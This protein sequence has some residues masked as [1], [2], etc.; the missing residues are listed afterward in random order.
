MIVTGI[1]N[2]WKCNKTAQIKKNLIGNVYFAIVFIDV[3]I[4]YIKII[5]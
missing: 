5:N 4:K 3:F 1:I 2:I